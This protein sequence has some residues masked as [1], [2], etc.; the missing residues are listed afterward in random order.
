VL[1][2]G[3]KKKTQCFE[4][5][6]KQQRSRAVPTYKDEIMVTNQSVYPFIYRKGRLGKGG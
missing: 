2:L 3:R 1:Y 5:T 4:A 6:G